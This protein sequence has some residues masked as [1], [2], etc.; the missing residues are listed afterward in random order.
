MKIIE[1]Y[2]DNKDYSTAYIELDKYGLSPKMIQKLCKS[3][4]NA[5]IVTQRIKQNP[6]LLADEVDGIGWSKADDIA[7]KSGHKNTQ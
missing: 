7:L 4:G 5:N 2:Q 1:K 6:Y 3:Y